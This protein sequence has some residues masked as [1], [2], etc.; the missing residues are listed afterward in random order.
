MRLTRLVAHASRPAAP[1]VVGLLAL[2]ALTA[3]F[4]QAVDPLAARGF[5]VTAG[6]AAG[7]LDDR[8]CASCHAALFASYQEVG[9]ARSFFRPGAGELIEDFAGVGYEHLPS[10]RRYEMIR[11]GDDITFRRYQVDE[12]GEPINVYEQRVDWILGSGHAARSYLYRTPGGE[13]YQLRICPRVLDV[14]A[15]TGRGRS[16]CGGP[17]TTRAQSNRCARP[18]SIP[19]A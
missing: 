14:S 8:R 2:I 19:R 17:S 6:A 18:S 3:A 15:A 4:R 16:M 9:M 7:Y 10:Q 1:V 12:T 11:Q 13:L 5:R